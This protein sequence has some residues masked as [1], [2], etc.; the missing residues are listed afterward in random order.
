MDVSDIN[1]KQ[2]VK[3]VTLTLIAAILIFLIVYGM[4][5]VYK[6]H[7]II[8]IG[9]F[10][11]N[12][13]LAVFCNLNEQMGYIDEKGNIAIPAKFKFAGPFLSDIAVVQDVNGKYGAIN[14]NGDYVIKPEFFY[15]SIFSDDLA[16]ICEL[17]D[18]N[19]YCSFHEN[20]QWGFIDKHGKIVVKTKY[21][22]VNDFTEGICWVGQSDSKCHYIDKTGK[23][24]LSEYDRCSSFINGYAGVKIDKTWNIINRN[25]KLI[26]PHIK[27]QS[28]NVWITE[29]YIIFHLEGK[30]NKFLNF[31]TLTQ[32]TFI[33]SRNFLICEFGLYPMVKDKKYGFINMN[34]DWVI[35]PVYEKAYRFTDGL[36]AVKV[37]DKW[38]FI[39]QTGKNVISPSYIEEPSL[40][41]NGYAQIQLE[42]YWGIINKHGELVIKIQGKR[43]NRMLWF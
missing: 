43:Q 8:D 38:G 31:D 21:H 35:P 30:D 26:V 29:K 3:I 14:K 25:G 5:T 1:K 23:K 2:V 41:S 4:I 12:N 42:D 22:N 15:I 37:N 11:K 27:T 10:S 34:D 39:D 28:D 6:N 33:T 40:F 9:C 20:E 36:A 17:D 32:K 13:G 18:K 19:I 24:I 16:A 7:K